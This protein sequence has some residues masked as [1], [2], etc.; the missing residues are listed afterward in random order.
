[1]ERV[2]TYEIQAAF[3]DLIKELQKVKDLT[4]ISI[5][6]KETA[7][8]LA[9]TLR[10]LMESSKDANEQNIAQMK[11]TLESYLTDAKAQFQQSG[12]F[13]VEHAEQ[14]KHDVASLID[15]NEMLVNVINE[16]AKSTAESALSDVKNMVDSLS[17]NITTE[18]SKI[19]KSIGVQGAQIQRAAGESTKSII[20]FQKSFEQHCNNISDTLSRLN[21]SITEQRSDLANINDK[22]KSHLVFSGMTCAF[23]LLI[24]VLLFVLVL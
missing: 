20:E 12:A 19:E 17:G 16:S 7:A 9:D 4:D 2:N 3:N 15:K 14:F 24:S 13:L 11:M 10:V 6:Y 18:L 5:S 8:N 21:N 22:M 23:M 1:M